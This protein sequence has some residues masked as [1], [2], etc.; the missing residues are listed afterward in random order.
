M[1]FFHEGVM[2]WFTQIRKGARLKLLSDECG[3]N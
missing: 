1:N 2:F 3:D